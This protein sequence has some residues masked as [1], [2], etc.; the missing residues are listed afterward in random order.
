[1]IG[2][3]GR[4]THQPLLMNIAFLA[5]TVI[6][7]TPILLRA[8]TA[9]QVKVISIE[10]LVTIAV[11][12]ALAIGELEESAVVTFLFVLGS[13]LEQKTLQRT[14]QSIKALTE[15]APKTAIQINDDQSQETVD[16]DMIDEG[17][18]LLVRTGD[19]VPVDGHI[20]TG[21]TSL[22]E[23]YITGEA[24]PVTKK[25]GDQVFMG[26]IND[27][28]PITVEADKVGEETTFGK[29]IELIEDA[30]DNQAPVARFIDRFAQYYTPAVLAI[31][32]LI[33][34]FTRDFRLAITFLVLGCPGALVIGAPVSNVAGI[35]RGA[36]SKILVKGGSVI[37]SLNKVD[38]ILFDKTGTITTGKPTVSHFFDYQNDVSNLALAG[39]MEMATSHPLGKA[40]V[41]YAKQQTEIPNEAIDI[42]TKNGVGLTTTVGG[43]LIQLGSPNVIAESQIKLTDQQ[44]KDLHE[45]Q[46]AGESV[47]MMTRENQLMLMF[48]IVDQLRPGVADVL[49]QLRKMGVQHLTMLTGDNLETATRIGQQ[50]G[51][52]E[53]QAGML[54]AD[55]ASYLKQLQSEGHHVLFVGDGINDGPSLAQAD[56]GIAMGSGTDTAI[57]TS[58]VVLIDSDF[59]N[60]LKAKKLARKTVWNTTENIVI[61]IATVLILL[62]GLLT[63][64]VD[65]SLG[66]LVHEGSILVVILNAMRLLRVKL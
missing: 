39:Q 18:H 46:T 8:I 24:Q 48:G 37:D 26:T 55:K 16:V 42:I 58:D 17:D 44:Q 21:S 25:V 12:G 54:P 33:F 23:A 10:L 27:G 29:I 41:E 22:N 62:L 14:H 34:A 56:V 31:A 53:I 57:E 47:V 7:G 49:G 59:K 4:F 28:D 11:V 38:T 64:Y 1:M 61:A 20:L 43:S 40:I 32:L 5:A 9:L 65:M 36:Q 13:F 66:M 45:I 63:D 30:Q 15:M 2:Y 52:T 60:V 3:I 50:A 6:A 35:G 19:Q 51:V